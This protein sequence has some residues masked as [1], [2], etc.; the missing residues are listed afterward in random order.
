MTFD[1]IE[2][3]SVFQLPQAVHQEVGD[4]RVEETRA[5]LRCENVPQSAVML[6]MLLLTV[7]RGQLLSLPSCSM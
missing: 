6:L 1:L 5:Q 2:C 3:S 7:T 4:S